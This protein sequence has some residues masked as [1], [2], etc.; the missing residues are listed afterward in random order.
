MDPKDLPP[1][2]SGL[3]RLGGQLVE[4]GQS[5]DASSTCRRLIAAVVVMTRRA[6]ER[7]C[8]WSQHNGRNAANASDVEV[9]LK[10]QARHF[11]GTLDDPDVVTE[12]LE[13]ERDIFGSDSD[14]ENEDADEDTGEDEDEDT[15]EDA[16]ENDTK[17][18]P[19]A[20]D[21]CAE[22]RTAYETWG[23][24]APEDEIEQY[25][26]SRVDSAVKSTGT[27]HMLCLEMEI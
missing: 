10:H 6:A 3:G 22:M 2:R 26:K 9:A 14:T 12:I 25:L 24:W 17:K 19:C 27:S 7:A 20:C 8:T 23:T 15:G 5:T 16:D 21:F 4:P 11:L 18:T 13:A 1:L